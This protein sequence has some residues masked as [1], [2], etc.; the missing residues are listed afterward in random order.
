MKR[1][2]GLLR[3]IDLLDDD[4]A[5]DDVI[6]KLVQTGGFIPNERFDFIALGDAAI[7]DFNG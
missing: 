6:A 4:I 2:A 3:V 7:S 1:T 5:T